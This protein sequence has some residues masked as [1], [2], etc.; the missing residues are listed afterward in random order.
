[1]ISFHIIRA[2]LLSG[3]TVAAIWCQQLGSE[4]AHITLKKLHKGKVY[5]SFQSK[6]KKTVKLFRDMYLWL[7]VCASNDL[8]P[9][10]VCSEAKKHIFATHPTV[11][12]HQ[13]RYRLAYL[14]QRWR[15]WGCS[16]TSCCHSQP[17]LCSFAPAQKC[18]P[19][20]GSFALCLLFKHITARCLP[21]GRG[22]QRPYRIA[23]TVDSR[24][25][26]SNEP[27]KTAGAGE[28]SSLADAPVLCRAVGGDE[29]REGR[30]EWT[31]GRSNHWTQK[32]TAAASVIRKEA[33]LAKHYMNIQPWL[34]ND[35]LHGMQ[36][37]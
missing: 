35:G 3:N 29:G 34:D 4:S 7:C 36:V 32:E 23:L 1:M 11:K 18:L 33:V 22:G 37:L 16:Q 20:Y 25:Q 12:V 8:R 6:G 10:Q 21:V 17:H 27:L 19:V 2:C 28:P 31:V 24:V 14:H 13:V 15:R 26:R 5:K 30:W 9:T